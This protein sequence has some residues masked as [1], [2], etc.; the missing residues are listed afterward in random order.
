MVPHDAPDLERFPRFR[1]ALAAAQVAELEPG[2]AIYIPYLWWHGV[3]SLDRFN[4]LANFWWHRD[5]VAAAHPQGALLRA[6]YEL[7]RT[8]PPEHRRAWQSMYEYWVFGIHG[9]PQ[10]HLPPAQ[11][12]TPARIDAQAIARFKQM[13]AELLS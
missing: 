9:D 6:T 3:Q 8:M 7:F 4:M 12:T 2:D 10:Q 13:L 1:D 11:R 5:P